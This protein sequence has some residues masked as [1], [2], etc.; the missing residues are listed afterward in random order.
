MGRRRF[1][2][3]CR[4]QRL[5]DRWFNTARCISTILLVVPWTIG[6]SF[7]AEPSAVSGQNDA[8]GIYGVYTGTFVTNNR[9]FSLE[10]A[11]TR[12]PQAN[13]LAAVFSFREL[14]TS[15]PFD[16]YA[17]TGDYD[18]LRKQFKL[19][20]R[21]WITRSRGR[22]VDLEGGFN[23]AS[24]KLEAIIS[25]EK[26]AFE[27]TPSP[28]KTK[29]L[30]ARIAAD[31]K[32]LEEGPVALAEAK[33]DD[34]KRG[35]L[36]RWFRRLK[37]EL[38]GLDFQHTTMNELSLKLITLF[39]D[40]N[41]VPVF[42]KPYDEL[43]VAERND[44]KQLGRKLFASRET[45]EL[46]EG[47]SDAVVVRPFEL[48]ICNNCFGDFAPKVA[49]KRKIRQTWLDTIEKLKSLPST[50]AGYDELLAIKREGEKPFANLAWSERQQFQ[51]AVE[52]A[53][54]GVAE[55]AL[56]EKVNLAVAAVGAEAGLAPLEDLVKNHAELFGLV[57][58]AA[59]TEANERI[60]TVLASSLENE[61][62]E[63]TVS[64]S[65]IVAVVGGNKW[66]AR[67]SSRY[68]FALSRQ[69]VSK[70]VDTLA[71]RRGADL[72]A[73]VAAI[74]AEISQ[75]PDDESAAKVKASY[76]MVPRDD[77]TD[78]GVKID[79]AVVARQASLQREKSMVFFSANERRWMQCDG[80][81]VPPNP[82]PPPTEDDLRSAIF[83]TFEAMGAKRSGVS[84][85][86]WGGTGNP[87][88]RAVVVSV[89]RVD[90]DSCKSEQDGFK[91]HYYM[92]A[93][94]EVHD[95]LRSFFSSGIPEEELIG[96]F[97]EQFEGEHDDRFVLGEHGWYSPTM[98]ERKISGLE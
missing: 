82:A 54:N 66:W 9:Y 36:V 25:G 22:Q 72:A 13:S 86:K 97:T 19:R 46:L 89:N 28:E 29:E 11:V 91:V 73:A 17:M 37:K 58:E 56:R 85:V 2:L 64:G 12:R 55:G 40:E 77:K 57:S 92:E 88:S 95:N 8:S 83:R 41:F 42:G 4:W 38:P 78:A 47:V 23:P 21:Q 15:G 65:G 33:S 74:T 79:K 27:L 70:A 50:S 75:Q 68:G 26:E 6:A 80:R 34:E 39:Y 76:L 44:L 45:G 84:T 87:P 94:C 7:A 1:R 60:D 69:P 20:A 63:N 35:V 5:V 67:L 52:S 32:R 16:S 18:A 14:G 48:G 30:E 53:E 71:S 98:R 24:G 61:E 90:L 43:T 51:K 81:I 3:K 10:L 59:K 49:L 62:H 31:E 96:A 93:T